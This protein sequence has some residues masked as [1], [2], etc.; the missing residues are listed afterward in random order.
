MIE[1]IRKSGLTP[2]AI[3]C[4]HGHFDHIAGVEP[5]KKVY[6]I[7]YYIHESDVRLSRSANFF[8]HVAKI[9][10]R[11]QIPTPDIKFKGPQDILRLGEFEVEVYN[12]PGHTLGSCVIKINQYLFTGDTIYKNGLGSEHIP[13]NQKRLLRNSITDIFSKFP[14]DSLVLPGHGESDTLGRIKLNNSKIK[15]F[16]ENESSTNH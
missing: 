15:N 8:L 10:Q 13:C 12:F 3:L 9:N 4:T 7:E 2:I 11:I 6:G 14:N 5:L 1:S 16:L